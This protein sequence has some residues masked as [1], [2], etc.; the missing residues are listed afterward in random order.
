MASKKPKADSGGSNSGTYSISLGGWRLSTSISNPDSTLYDGVYE[1]TSNYNVNSSTATMTIT[2]EG[3]NT[4]TMYIRSYA[5]SNYDYVM[6]GQLDKAITG[7][8]SYSSSDVKAHTRGNQQSGTTLSNYTKVEFT[9]IGG[10]RHTITVVYRKDGSAH[11][12]SDRGYVLIG[13]TFN[14]GSDEGG[15]SG[16]EQDNKITENYLTIVALEDG[17]TAT[18]SSLCEY[19]IDG[20]GDWKQISSKTESVNTGQTISFRG[21]LN[22]GINTYVFTV[23]KRFNLKGNC[24]SILFGDSAK[25]NYS[26]SSK[27]HAFRKLFYNC[28]TLISVSSNFLPSTVLS[29]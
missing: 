20:D 3:L 16:G 19:C 6:V 14:S 1:S 28:T 27:Q 2:I 26:L 29:S 12:G 21:N 9:G 4:F 7:S 15:D 5:E 10:G 13:K 17:L 22:T 23:N 8:T 25:D 18:F 24:T 11:S